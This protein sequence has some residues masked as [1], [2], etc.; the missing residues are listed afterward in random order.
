MNKI[1]WANVK[2]Q[3]FTLILE[4]SNLQSPAL[5]CSN[6]KDIYEWESGIVEVGAYEGAESQAL[7]FNFTDA[8][9]IRTVYLDETS[10][11]SKDF[12]TLERT[13]ITFSK[14]AYVMLSLLDPIFD[15]RLRTPHVS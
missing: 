14:V 1:L 2:S 13:M 11:M 7:F 15:S 4:T 6:A 8:H 10:W 5:G 9:N 12:T 3:N